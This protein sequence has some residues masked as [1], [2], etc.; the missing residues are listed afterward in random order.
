MDKGRAPQEL[1]VGTEAGL[2]RREDVYSLLELTGV[3]DMT[4]YMRRMA[5]E[6]PKMTVL[7]LKEHFARLQAEVEDLR[8]QGKPLG[9]SAEAIREARNKRNSKAGVLRTR[10]LSHRSSGWHSLSQ[11][12]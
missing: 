5:P 7:E 2:L 12:S 11:S 6:V 1:S 4:K 8:R 3:D 9:N 10:L